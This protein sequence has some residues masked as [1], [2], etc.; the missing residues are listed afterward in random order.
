MYESNIKRPNTCDCIIKR[1]VR[2]LLDI[3]SYLHIKLHMCDLILICRN[4]IYQDIELR[5]FIMYRAFLYNVSYRIAKEIN[6]RRNFI[7]CFSN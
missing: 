2:G 4:L 1:I 3:D 5:A 7:F 6:I